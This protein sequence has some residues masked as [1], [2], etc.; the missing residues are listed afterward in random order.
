MLYI[1]KPFRIAAR[2]D[3]MLD[4][5]V[6]EEMD[7]TAV[8]NTQPSVLSYLALHL[9]ISSS[10]AN[11]RCNFDRSINNRH[12]STSTAGY[13]PQLNAKQRALKDAKKAM[14][15][16]TAHVDLKA[17]H[18]KRDCLPQDVSKACFLRSRGQ[19]HAEA[20][21]N[22]VM[23]KGTVKAHLRIVLKRCS[24]TSRRPTKDMPMRRIAWDCFVIMAM[25]DIT[26]FTKPCT[27]IN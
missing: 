16:A 11:P 15:K 23:C 22:L 5:V 8:F 3:V 10:T 14:R 25:V 4:V 9:R 17:L 19:G 24:G 18:D 7:P 6:G 21:F 2:L 12:P 20:Q 27:G 26:T 1:L 13:A